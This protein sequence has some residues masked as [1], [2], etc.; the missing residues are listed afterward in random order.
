MHDDFA[1]VLAAGHIL[2]CFSTNVSA[3]CRGAWFFRV[4][5]LSP[6]KGKEPDTILS[7]CCFNDPF[8]RAQYLSAYT[9]RTLHC[10]VSFEEHRL[11]NIQRCKINH[12]S[13]KGKQSKLREKND[14]LCGYDTACANLYL[15]KYSEISYIINCIKL[16]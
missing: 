12:K 11:T 9:R 5:R 16:Q 10:C 15:L 6:D 4:F 3:F 1:A 8:Q 13:T 14:F 2:L 7:D